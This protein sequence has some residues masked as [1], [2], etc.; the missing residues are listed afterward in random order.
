MDEQLLASEEEKKRKPRPPP[1]RVISP[2]QSR[3]RYIPRFTNVMMEESWKRKSKLEDLE[4]I[5]R[6][7]SSHGDVVYLPHGLRP[8]PQASLAQNLRNIS[9]T[10]FIDPERLQ[11][12]KWIGQGSFSTV[13]KCSMKLEEEEQE[14]EEKEIMVAV[15]RPRVEFVSDSS[16]DLVWFVKEA[17]IVH[18]LQHPNIINFIGVGAWED[19]RFQSGSEELIFGNLFMVEEYVGS[20]TL[21]DVIFQKWRTKSRQSRHFYS[22]ECVEMDSVNCEWTKLLTQFGSQYNTSRFKAGKRYNFGFQY[23]FRARGSYR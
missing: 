6:I 9:G 13:E 12:I 7:H 21:R 10:L 2:F 20:Q 23:K 14:G 15:K 5:S 3:G 17:D 8:S 4:E 11:Y 22:F 16:D 1:I 18:Q 19:E